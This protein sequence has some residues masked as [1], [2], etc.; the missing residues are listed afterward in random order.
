M[1][2]VNLPRGRTSRYYIGESHGMGVVISH[3][4]TFW[5]YL[6]ILSCPKVD[7]VI[8]TAK[9]FIQCTPALFSADHQARVNLKM[10]RYGKLTEQNEPN[11]PPVSRVGLELKILHSHLR[12]ESRLDEFYPE[13]ATGSEIRL[14]SQRFRRAAATP[15]YWNR[16]VDLTMCFL[17]PVCGSLFAGRTGQRN[18]LHIPLSIQIW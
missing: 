10:G 12:A 5:L 18:G 8:L 17:V 3:R 11:G 16:V 4:I 2:H 1:A 7:K 9:T 13:S 15:R 6:D 14:A